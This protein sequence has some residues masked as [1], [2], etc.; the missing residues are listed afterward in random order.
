MDDEA[1]WNDFT[2]YSFGILVRKDYNKILL[3]FDSAANSDPETLERPQYLATRRRLA[4]LTERIQSC[5]A[6]CQSMPARGL[7]LQDIEYE[8]IKAC[9]RVRI[10]VTNIER[11]LSAPALK[12]LTLQ[13]EAQYA[14]LE[15]GRNKPIIM[16]L[17]P[18]YDIVVKSE[19]RFTA[20]SSL[21]VLGKSLSKFEKIVEKHKVFLTIEWLPC[22]EF[23]PPA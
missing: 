1:L 11:Q 5:E 21:A 16:N 18:F 3:A 4:N 9:G 17:N 15:I 22:I 14:V 10:V 13:H 6:E 7:I 19:K 8:L 23:G 20:I 12:S 2:L